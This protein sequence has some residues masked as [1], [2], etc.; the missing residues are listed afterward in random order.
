M[1]SAGVLVSFNLTNC[2]L[3]MIRRSDP[4][5]ENLTLCGKLLLL[6]NGLCIGLVFTLFYV[7]PEHPTAASFYPLWFCVVL[8]MSLGLLYIMYLLGKQCPENIDPDAGSEFRAYFVPY[9]PMIGTLISVGYGVQSIGLKSFNPPYQSA[10]SF[11]PIYPIP[12]STYS[13]H[14]LN[15]PSHPNLSTHPLNPSSL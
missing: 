9:S 8:P 14:P 3:L 15:P 5:Q 12:Q 1:I 6:Y 2:A 10:L 13:T 7:M 4:A 11:H